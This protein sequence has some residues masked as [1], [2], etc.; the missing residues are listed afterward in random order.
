MGKI[1]MDK[2]FRDNNI[3]GTKMPLYRQYY[4]PCGPPIYFSANILNFAVFVQKEHL[5]PRKY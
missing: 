2:N 3:G 1:F 5:Q 4:F